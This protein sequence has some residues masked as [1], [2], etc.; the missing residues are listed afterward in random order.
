MQFYC[1]WEFSADTGSSPELILADDSSHAWWLWLTLLIPLALVAYGAADLAWLAGAAPASSSGVPRRN[2]SISWERFG[3]DLSA[4]QPDLPTVPPIDAVVDSPGVKL[5][6]RLPIDAA[7]GRLSVALAIVCVV[8]NL[9]VADFLFHVIRWPRKWPTQ[10]ADHL[11]DGAVFH[12]R[13]VDHFRARP[14]DH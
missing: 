2:K 11:A 14:P 13:S 10:L 12:G 1:S 7:P 3:I 6:C 5:A 9:L 4:G 8:W